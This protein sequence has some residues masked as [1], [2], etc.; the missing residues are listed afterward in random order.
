MKFFTFSSSPLVQIED[1]LCSKCPPS[2][3]LRFKL[4]PHRVAKAL[5]KKYMNC[6]HSLKSRLICSWWQVV[7][8][9]TLFNQTKS[10]KGQGRRRRPWAKCIIILGNHCKAKGGVKRRNGQHELERNPRGKGLSEWSS[11]VV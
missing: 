5:A 6:S 2:E 8:G 9:S 4:K 1:L 7:W 11:K 3:Q 10:W